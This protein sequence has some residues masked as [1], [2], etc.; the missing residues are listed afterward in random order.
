MNGG[1]G[2]GMGPSLISPFMST[3]IA[4]IV[5]IEESICIHE[6]RRIVFIEEEKVQGSV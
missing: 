6:Y 1:M 3:R 5:V 4:V 2:P